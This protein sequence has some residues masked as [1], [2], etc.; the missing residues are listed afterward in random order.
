MLDRFRMLLRGASQL[1][2]EAGLPAPAKRVE[3]KP[4][5]VESLLG[6]EVVNLDTPQMQRFVAGKRVMITGAGGSIGSEICRQVARFLPERLVLVERSEGNLFEIDR[7]LRERWIGQQVF[8]EV[9]D[10]TDVERCSGVFQTHKP[11]VV[12]H[13]AAH[14]HVPM[15]EANPGEAIKNNVVGTRVILDLSIE[16]EAQSFV[17]ISTDKAINPSSVMG[18]SKRLAEMLVQSRHGMGKTRVAAVRFGNVLGSS[19]S[20][21]PI[22]K[23]QIERGGPVTVTHE[24]MTRYFMTIPEATQ[25]VMQ[26]GAIGHGGE[27]FLLDMGKPV[28]IID[29]ARRMIQDAGLVEGTDI[30]LRVVGIRPGEKLHE[31][32]SHATER[33][34]PTSH[35]RIRVWELPEVSQSWLKMA[36]A[37]LE[38]KSNAP[39]DEVIRALAHWM[40]EYQ[41]QQVMAT[42]RLA[43]AVAA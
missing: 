32:L 17:L 9:A 14:K 6:R 8:A 39:A 23:Q 41:P 42:P 22:F 31:E 26:A 13:A 40:Q 27:V 5:S 21:V 12:F 19:G 24:E 18:A 3:R 16:H 43:D 29:M 28:K 30:E 11:D 35:P 34:R 38:L 7:E 2:E 36:I 33:A 4:F 37:D 25:L 10:I 15:M 20:V 1:K